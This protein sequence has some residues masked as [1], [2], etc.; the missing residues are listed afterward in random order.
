MSFWDI[1]VCNDPDNDYDLVYELR[2][3]GCDFAVIEQTKKGLELIL[4]DHSLGFPVPLDWILK[5]M[6]DAQKHLPAGRI[7]NF[8][9][10]EFKMEVFE[11]KG[12]RFL[13]YRDK[14]KI[15]SI[16]QKKRGLFLILWEEKTKIIIPFDWLLNVMKRA[17]EELPAGKIENMGE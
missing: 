11:G 5:V 7:E 6:L 12:G 3:V 15:A 4:F 8:G 2:F 16:V 10:E 9:N 17:K 1:E 14:K 13:L